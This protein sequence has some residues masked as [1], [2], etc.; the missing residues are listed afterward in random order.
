M[1][2]GTVEPMIVRVGQGFDIHRFEETPTPGRVLVLGGQRFPDER[3]LVGHSD[4]DVIAHAVIDA[5]LG[6]AGLGDIGQHFPDTDPKWKDAGSIEILRLVAKMLVDGGWNVGNVDC[7]VVCERPQ[8]AP[9][10]DAMQANLS[11]A[12]GAPVTVKGRRAEGLG[13]IGRS[14]GIACFASAVVTRG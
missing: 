13:A 14:E 9:A 11:G 4:A 12:A 10:R 8:L 1:G 6:A 3:T 2:A 7:S 5:L